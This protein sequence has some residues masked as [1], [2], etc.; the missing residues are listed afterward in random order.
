[1]EFSLRPM[2][3]A[4]AEAVEAL[5]R[6]CPEAGQWLPSNA[7]PQRA[8]VAERGGRIE[9]LAVWQELPGGEAELLNLAVHPQARRRGA[10]RALLGLLEGRKIWLEV[11]ESNTGAI[12]FYRAQGFAVCGRRRAYYANPVEDAILMAR[13]ALTPPRA[14]G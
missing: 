4:D 11:R 10:A 3:P 12:R 5:L 8:F 2:T 7:P 13:D 14:A 9:G 1:M 6:L